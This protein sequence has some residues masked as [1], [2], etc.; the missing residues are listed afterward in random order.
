MRGRSSCYCDN[1]FIT[2]RE[3]SGNFFSDPLENQP[4]K[5]TFTFP[6]IYFVNTV[7]LEMHHGGLSL[8]RRTMMEGREAGWM[9]PPFNPFQTRLFSTFWDQGVGDFR[10]PPSLC[11]FKTTYA[12]A[13]KFAQD[14]VRANSNHYRYCD[15]TVT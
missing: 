15:V 8:R 1:C 11:N 6:E 5:T 12:M 13:T 10:S 4:S 2:Q 7:T 14:S 9:P 3:L